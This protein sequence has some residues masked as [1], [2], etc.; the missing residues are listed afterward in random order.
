MLPTLAAFFLF[1][2]PE[3]QTQLAVNPA[4]VA[5]HTSTTARAARA[6]HPVVIDGRDDDDVWKN[7]PLISDFLEFDP[8]EGKEARFKTEAKVA[9]DNRR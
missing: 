9:Y 3:T 7:A 8:V 4:K 5:P 1:Q 6:A 2:A